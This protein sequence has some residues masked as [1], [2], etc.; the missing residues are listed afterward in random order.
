MKWLGDMLPKHLTFRHL[1]HTV[2]IEAV[3][4]DKGSP[5]LKKCGHQLVGPCP[6][7]GGDNPNAFVVSPSKNIWRCFTKCNGGGDVID[8]VCRM[9]SKTYY[10]TAQYL[11]SISH[12]FP[13][14]S[15]PI[16]TPCRKPP[17]KPFTRNLPLDYKTAW[18]KGKGITEKTASYFEAGLYQ[19]NG[20][21]ADCIAVRIHDLKGRPIGYTGRRLIDH[22]IRK[23]GKW[24]FPP[25]L[26]KSHIL[27]NFH[28]V[29]NNLQK[30]LFVVEGPWGVMRLAQ[31]N[32][33][34]V[35][36]LGINLSNEQQRIL[37]KLPKIV[38][39]LDGDIP[40]RK[41]AKHIHDKLK[42]HTVVRRVNLNFNTDPDDL[43]DHQLTKLAKLLSF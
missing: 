5:P 43:Q 14:P 3:L 22:Q 26:P 35:A 24:K 38:L 27:Y 16:T 31:I 23:Y 12:A 30:G 11:A 29:R 1:K 32:I 28:R 8:L 4:H 17:F 10:E 40:G 33:P 13:A 20:F 18:F 42:I 34:A 41:A 25:Q 19:G 15:T 39:M 7:H 36:L 2:S 6:V 21:L 37:C 9:D